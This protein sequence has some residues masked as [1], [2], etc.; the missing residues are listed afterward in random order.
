[1]SPSRS[2]GHRTQHAVVAR[3]ERDVQVA[4][5]GRRLAQS[6]E[7]R[8]VRWLTSIEDS[9]SRAS[10]GV[11]PTSR[12]SAAGRSRLAVAVAAEVDPGEHD[13]A[14]ALVDAAAHLGEHGIGARLREAPRTSGITQKLQEK[15]QPSCTFTNAR[16]R[17]SRASA[18]TQPIAPTS[19]AIA[20]GGLLARL[21]DDDDVLRQ[22]GE[23][24]GE[25]L[26][27]QPVTYTRRC[28]RAARDAAWRDLRSA[29][30]VTQQVFSTATSP[31]SRSAWPSASRRS[32]TACAS[33]CE[34]L[35][36]RKSTENVAIGADLTASD[37]QVGRPAL[38]SRR[39]RGGSRA[40]RA[41]ATR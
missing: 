37:V 20:S 5:H 23:R 25:R 15:L 33:A 9:R 24:V 26:A 40:A 17:S 35:Q 3:L 1:M 34:T 21:R 4:R 11:A 10:P 12:I 16:T 14:V 30:C 38:G 18:W 28:V 32:R 29:S 36:P 22:T 27:P 39:V 13:L 19:P 31:P 7:Q 6:G 41:L 2:G 8:S